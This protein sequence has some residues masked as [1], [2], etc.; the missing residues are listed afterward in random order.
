MKKET[1]LQSCNILFEQYFNF[2]N[3]ISLIQQTIQRSIPTG[4][5]IS[6]NDDKTVS[7]ENISPDDSFQISNTQSTAMNEVR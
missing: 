4:I 2:I 5:R 1:L 7:P 6:Q 3:S